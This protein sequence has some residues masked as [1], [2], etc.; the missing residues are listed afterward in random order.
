MI[1]T[2]VDEV[3]RGIIIKLI[4]IFLYY[5]MVDE[6]LKVYKG[7]RMG[8]EYFINLIDFFGY[9]DFLSEVIVVFRIID[10]VFVVVDCIEG[11]CLNRNCF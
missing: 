10:G 1:D 8:N 3:E 6:V 7:E 4:G 2:R 9:V 11:V 5:E